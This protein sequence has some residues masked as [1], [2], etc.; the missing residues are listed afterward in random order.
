M[1]QEISVSYQAIKSKLYRLIDALVVGEKTETEVQESIRRWWEL[2]HPADRPIAQKYLLTVLERSR[3]ALEAVE[4]GL[5]EATQNEEIRTPEP[6]K[7]LKMVGRVVK[8]A[9][10]SSPTI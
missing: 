7:V 10:F 8:Q 6:S 1:P 9:T 4:G 3:L 2:I 5:M